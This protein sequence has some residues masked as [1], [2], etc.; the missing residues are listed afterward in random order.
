M[1]IERRLS[2][3]ETI[4]GGECVVIW[5]HHTE[6]DEQAKARWAADNPGRGRPGSRAMV[7]GWLPPEGDSTGAPA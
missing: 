4:T 3:L 6:T 5:R 1:N 2:K 7:V